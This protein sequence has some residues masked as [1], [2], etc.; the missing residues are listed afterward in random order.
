VTSVNAPDFFARSRVLR[1]SQ[2]WVARIDDEVVGSVATSVK[3]ADPDGRGL[4]YVFQL[5][6]DPSFRAQGVGSALL[7]KGVEVLRQGGVGQVYAYVRSENGDGARAFQ[8]AGFR[9]LAI[10]KAGYP[11]LFVLLGVLGLAA[12]LALCFPGA[13]GLSRRS[14]P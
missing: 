5:F 1:D 11:G 7:A 3:P 4:G 14:M 6:V 12:T 8:R 13:Q 9:A 2:V 10:E